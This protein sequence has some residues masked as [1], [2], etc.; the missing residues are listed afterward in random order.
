[1]RYIPSTEARDK[2]ISYHKIES[3]VPWIVTDGSFAHLL[4]KYRK[5]EQ[6]GLYLDLGCGNGETFRPALNYFNEFAG[7][8]IVDYR[9]PFWK[10]RSSFHTVDLNFERLLFPDK[11][12]DMVTA[13]QTIEHLENPFFVMREVKRVLKPTGLFMFSV[14][15]PYNLAF[16]LKFLLTNNMPPWTRENNHLLFFTKAVFEKTYLAN[17]TLLETVHSQGALPGFGRLRLLFGKR[18]PK[19][20]N[21]L[22]RGAWFSRRVGY[23]LQKKS[24]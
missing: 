13:F 24:G 21:V 20:L 12:V 17:F 7:V 18:L 23:C 5:P 8:D 6:R 22:P 14:P 19:H 1:M 10:D 3:M 9:L 4:R 11:S 15:N 16:K 2:N